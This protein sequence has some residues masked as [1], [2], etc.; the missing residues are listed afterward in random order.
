VVNIALLAAK[1]H[2]VSGD[3]SLL[4]VGY[5]PLIEVNERVQNVLTVA[6]LA[7]S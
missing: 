4:N 2:S 1:C 7:R 3:E 5:L 6:V